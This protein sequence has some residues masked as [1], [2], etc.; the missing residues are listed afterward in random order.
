MLKYAFLHI[1]E[2]IYAE[3]CKKYAEI[4]RNM[5]KYGLPRI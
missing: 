4:C 2:K 1:N 3:I 5:Q